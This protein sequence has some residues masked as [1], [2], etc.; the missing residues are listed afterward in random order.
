MNNIQHVKDAHLNHTFYYQHL[1][2]MLFSLLAVCYILYAVA[3]EKAI[4]VTSAMAIGH[5]LYSKYGFGWHRKLVIKAIGDKEEF[6]SLLNKYNLQV[7]QLY[8][9]AVKS[10]ESKEDLKNIE[11]LIGFSEAIRSV[12]KL[13]KMYSRAGF[14]IAVVTIAVFVIN[15]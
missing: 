6:S 4:C 1:M 14:I 8:S 7:G 11:A 5:I 9:E 10:I 2:V 15:A 3:I 12:S 13:I